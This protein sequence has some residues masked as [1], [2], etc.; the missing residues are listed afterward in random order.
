[1]SDNNTI[2]VFGSNLAGIHGAGAALHARL[3]HDAKMGVGA[4][5]TGEA[6]AIPTKNQKLLTLPL[7]VVRIHVEEFLLYAR[8]HPDLTFCVTRVG[9]GLAGYT[10]PDIAPLFADAPGNCILPREW[11]KIN[12]GNRGREAHAPL[13]KGT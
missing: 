12:A 13:K 9:C 4:G 5:P 1:M 8:A 10:D 2:F 3:H 6:Y 11:T 7:V